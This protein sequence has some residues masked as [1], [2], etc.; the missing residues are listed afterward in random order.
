MV[1]VLKLDDFW[2]R[3]LKKTEIEI[4]CPESCPAHLPK[5]HHNLDLQTQKPKPCTRTVGGMVPQK[6]KNS[7]FVEPSSGRR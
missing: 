7:D 4:E 3:S 6:A 1:Y 5:H 2:A